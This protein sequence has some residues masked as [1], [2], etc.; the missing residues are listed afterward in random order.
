M[1]KSDEMS[2]DQPFGESREELWRRAANAAAGSTARESR[3]AADYHESQTDESGEGTT[4]FH[5]T[6]LRLGANGF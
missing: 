6:L 3:E 4:E 5:R 2:F 1:F